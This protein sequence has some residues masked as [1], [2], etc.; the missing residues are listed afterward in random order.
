MKE[1]FD[2][3]DKK[4]IVALTGDGQLSAGKL[5]EDLGVTGPTVRTRLRALMDSGL[6]RIS[7][8]VDPFRATG[9]TVALV[10]IN[11]SSHQQLGEKMDQIAELPDVS[12]AAV[13]TGRYDII[14]EVVLTE[15]MSDLYRFMDEDLASVGGIDA[16][17]SFV[18]MKARRKWLCL[19]KGTRD[20]FVTKDK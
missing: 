8:L 9:L 7:A 17:E 2:A 4:L 3:L 6:C 15:A 10:G 5:A 11:L 13:V 20:R 16:S 18:V 1:C 12:W 19:P 14:A